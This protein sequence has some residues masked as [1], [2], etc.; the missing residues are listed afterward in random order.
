[1]IPR[2]VEFLLGG[3]SL[4]IFIAIDVTL[5]TM[6]YYDRTRARQL[7]ILRAAFTCPFWFFLTLRQTDL[8]TARVVGFEEA[9]ISL[10]LIVLLTGQPA[11]WRRPVGIALFL[12]YAF[13]YLGI[14]LLVLATPATSHAAT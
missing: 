10:S 13:F 6:L 8:P 9:L 7:T 12:T 2:A 14:T 1:M 3:F 5:A 11:R 4:L